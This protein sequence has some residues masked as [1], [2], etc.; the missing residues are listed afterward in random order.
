MAGIQYGEINRCILIGGSS[1]IPCIRR[2]LE[3]TFS[4]QKVVAGNI[5]EGVARGA[6]LFAAYL[7]DRKAGG[8]PQYMNRWDSIEIQENTAHNIGV[9]TGVGYSVIIKQNA[10]TPASGAKTYRPTVLSENGEFAIVPS[11]DVYQGGGQKWANVGSVQ[12]P[13]IYAHGRRPDQINIQIEFIAESTQILSKITVQ[14]GNADKSDLI[15]TETL[16]LS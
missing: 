3:Q 14:Q 16:K 4:S 8:E 11:I 10:A 9:R 7:L 6:S 1:K 12:M 2:F 13:T 5:G 15:V